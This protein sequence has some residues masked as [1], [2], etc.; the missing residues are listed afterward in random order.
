MLAQIL[1]YH[2]LPPLE[3]PPPLPHGPD[4][5]IIRARSGFIPDGIPACMGADGGGGIGQDG[6]G[7]GKAEEGGKVEGGGCIGVC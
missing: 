2:P 5:A 6:T 4:C 7:G 3:P 1:N